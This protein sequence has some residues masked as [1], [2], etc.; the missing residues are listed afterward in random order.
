MT[1]KI[2][3][4]MLQDQ[5]REARNARKFPPCKM[6]KR[7][8]KVPSL[9]STNISFIIGGFHC[10][11]SLKFHGDNTCSYSWPPTLMLVFDCILKV[12]A[13]FPNQT[14]Q[15]K[16][17]IHSVPNPYLLPIKLYIDDMSESNNL[18]LYKVW[19][20]PSLFYFLPMSG[21]CF[22]KHYVHIFVMHGHGRM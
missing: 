21:V 7:Q 22:V 19:V 4:T 9:T 20:F 11:Q 1:T 2:E 5:I 18:F 6:L 17:Y 14:H 8:R 12:G 10:G 13:S 15:K 3:S 16:I